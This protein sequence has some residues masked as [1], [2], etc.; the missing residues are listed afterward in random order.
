MTVDPVELS[1]Y[2]DGELTPERACYVAR[3][4]RS[5][6]TAQAMLRDWQ[7]IRSALGQLPVDSSLAEPGRTDRILSGIERQLASKRAKPLPRAARPVGSIPPQWQGSSVRHDVGWR[8]VTAGIALAASVMLVLTSS[9]SPTLPSTGSAEPVVAY[10]LAVV[11]HEAAAAAEEPQGA[12]VESVDFGD[13][14]GAVFLVSANHRVTPVV[15]LSSDALT[16]EGR[17]QA[18]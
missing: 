12:A 15:W 8:A 1:A 10:G 16:E 17:T 6:P 5:D 4:L 18:L 13:H 11:N 9:N 2:F 14:A 3:A 7:R